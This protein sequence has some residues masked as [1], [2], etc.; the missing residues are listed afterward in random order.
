[1]RSDGSSCHHHS[2]LILVAGWTL[3]VLCPLSF[4]PLS[5]VLCPLSSVLCPLSSVLCP[6][7]SVLCPLSSCPMASVLCPWFS[8]LLPL[9]S[10]PLSSVLCPLLSVLCSLSS[11]L[12]PLSSVLYHRSIDLSLLLPASFPDSQP[13]AVGVE[14]I[15]HRDDRV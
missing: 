4:C 10:R 8:V 3:L 1:M 6:L 2:A 13:L 15:V 7:S 12:C 14:G 9:S 11:V 5:S